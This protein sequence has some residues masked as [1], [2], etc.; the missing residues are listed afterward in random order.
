MRFL[1]VSTAVIDEIESPAGGPRNSVLGGAGV[2]ALAGTKVWHDDAVLI[3]G[4]GEDFL[5]EQG[6]WFSR[7]QLSTRGL[8]IRDKNTA[9]T[10]IQYLADG[11]RVET[12]VYGP[13]HY[14]RLTASA[15]DIGRHCDA[16]TA[17][18]YVFRD[19]EQPFWQALIRLKASFGF[20]LMWEVDARAAVPERLP[21]LLAVLEHVD[22][23]SLNRREALTLFATDQIDETIP[24]LQQLRLPLV[25]LRLG[26]DGAVIITDGTQYPIPPVPDLHVVDPTGAGNSSSGAVLV[27]YC[28][29]Q[30][31]MTI[32]LMGTISAA[33]C[34]AQYGPPP[35]L[36]HQVRRAAQQ[37]MADLRR[38][39]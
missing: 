19:L 39:L 21:A 31:P 30:D 33:L 15:A 2:Y 35:V 27:G 23:L 29:G 36:D 24:Q 13:D 3:T 37:T 14:L 9:H 25:Y 28:A 32:G 11:E 5:A 16:D 18:V 26:A 1:I 7:N 20:K 22:I 17:G 8:S 6:D 34:L 38:Q 12:P 4:I 10:I